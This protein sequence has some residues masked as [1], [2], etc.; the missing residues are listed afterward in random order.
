MGKTHRGKGLKAL[1]NHG[2]DTCPLCKRTAIKVVFEVTVKEKTIKVCK[3]CKAAL[4]NG[5]LQKEA[6]AIA[7]A[8]P[9]AAP[10]AGA[11]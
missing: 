11:P 6:E 1:A 3:T 4:S 10:A 9:A 5:K 8:I 7:A 2:R